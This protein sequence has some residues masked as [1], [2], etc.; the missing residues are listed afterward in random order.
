ML[1][2]GHSQVADCMQVSKLGYYLPFA[3]F[4]GAVTAVGNGLISTFSP[5]TSTGK[6]IGYQIILGVGRGCGFQMV[7]PTYSLTLSLSLSLYVS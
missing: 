1:E 6:W 4:S 2:D 3:L 7:S 5:G